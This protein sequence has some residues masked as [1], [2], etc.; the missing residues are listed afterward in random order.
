MLPEC[1]SPGSARQGLERLVWGGVVLVVWATF[2]LKRDRLA[3]GGK[4]P[5]DNA[6]T[7]ERLQRAASDRHEPDKTVG[8]W[9]NLEP[10]LKHDG[11]PERSLRNWSN[12][13]FRRWQGSVESGSPV[14]LIS[15]F[16]PHALTPILQ[17]KS[18]RFV[19]PDSLAPN[20]MNFLLFL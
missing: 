10:F 14:S 2:S 16:Q 3:G 13:H 8:S 17:T 1:G 6:E 7:P 19:N 18:L 11:G 15:L 9:K 5:P 4:G 12:L 20:P